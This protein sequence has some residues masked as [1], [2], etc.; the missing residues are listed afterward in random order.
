MWDIGAISHP[1][2]AGFTPSHVPSA[3]DA[4]S[5]VNAR[6]RVDG[7]VQTLEGGR[8]ALGTAP[9]RRKAA[10]TSSDSTR[11]MGVATRPNWDAIAGN[12]ATM[13]GRR[14]ASFVGSSAQRGLAALRRR[15]AASTAATT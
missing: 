1:L 5:A 11:S 10:D 12:E 13:A 9:G 8:G 7:R 6:A 15:L 14:A 2:P 4:S 3:S